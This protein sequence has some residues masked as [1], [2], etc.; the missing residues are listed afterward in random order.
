MFTKV[1]IVIQFHLT[2][3]VWFICKISKIEINRLQNAF[4]RYFPPTDI[5]NLALC[6]FLFCLKFNDTLT[7]SLLLYTRF[8]LDWLNFVNRHWAHKKQGFV[9][10]YNWSTGRKF[11]CFFVSIYKNQI[12]THICGGRS[13]SI[14]FV[15]YAILSY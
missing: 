14:D 5:A 8:L 4:A 10:L 2:V 3:R 7:F 6:A 12:K 1:L 11:M 9:I 15:E 13:D